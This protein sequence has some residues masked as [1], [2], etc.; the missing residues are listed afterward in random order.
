[1][2]ICSTQAVR[3]KAWDLRTTTR[4]RLNPFLTGCL[5]ALSQ[6]LSP[7]PSAESLRKQLQ[8]RSKRSS[9]YYK[10]VKEFILPLPGEMIVS[11]GRKFP[12]E[13]MLYKI[14]G[15]CKSMETIIQ[16]HY[17]LNKNL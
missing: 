1:L 14:I 6:H 11:S 3:F 12:T 17:E 8:W 4:H 15:I 5:P 9:F 16:L 2:L 7:E 13:I 10:R